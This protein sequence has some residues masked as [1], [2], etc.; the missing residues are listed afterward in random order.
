MR[1]VD[2]LLFNLFQMNSLIFLNPYFFIFTVNF[3]FT[4]MVCAWLRL[5]LS[6]LNN[7]RENNTNYNRKIAFWLFTRREL[8]RYYIMEH[9]GDFISRRRKNKFFRKMFAI[10]SFL[11][12]SKIVWY[13]DTVFLKNLVKYRKTI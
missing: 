1:K 9:S 7:T 6:Q 8:A 2:E 10:L 3:F 11:H 13:F 5:S 4:G 12:I